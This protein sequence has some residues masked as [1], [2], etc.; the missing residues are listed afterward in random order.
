MSTYEKDL[1][2]LKHLIAS[3][4]NFNDYVDSL[5]VYEKREFVNDIDYIIEKTKSKY[6]NVLKLHL[7]IFTFFALSIIN[8][9]FNFSG[10]SASLFLLT[11]AFLPW[12][13]K[14]LYKN[15]KTVRT[16]KLIKKALKTRWIG[17]SE[18]ED[19]DSEFF[20]KGKEAYIYKK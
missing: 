2:S 1:N 3:T 11:F 9:K 6:K 20:T 18:I 12:F 17:E 8:L 16:Y 13:T 14:E 5:S 10:Y 15:W 19:D 4:G 7:F